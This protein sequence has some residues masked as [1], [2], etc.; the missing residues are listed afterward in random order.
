M[1]GILRYL[2]ETY[3]RYTSVLTGN[4]CQVYFG[5]CWELM[6]GILRYLLETYA[7]Y[8]SVPAGNLGQVEIKE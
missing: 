3:A 2:L 7:R 4:L 8:T 6:P 5:T 1:P